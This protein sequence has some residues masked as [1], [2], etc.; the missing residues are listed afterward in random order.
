MLR[1]IGS[2]CLATFVAFAPSSANA[3]SGM[4]SWYKMGRVTANGE[5][6]KPMGYTAAHRTL[7]FGTVVRVTNVKSGRSVVVRINDR[8]PFVHGRIIDLAQGAAQI[9]GLHRSGTAKVVVVV[10]NQ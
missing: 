4:A 5:R 9:I 7:K 6:F 8:G 10:L 2:C 1:L 3:Q